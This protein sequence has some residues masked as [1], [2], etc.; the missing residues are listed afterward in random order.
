[1]ELIGTRKTLQEAFSRGWDR[2]GINMIE[3][4][5]YG[6]EIETGD[7]YSSDNSVCDGVEAGYILAAV[8]KQKP[9]IAQ[10]LEFCYGMNNSDYRQYA[11][12]SDLFA[13]LFQ[14]KRNISG[15]QIIRHQNLCF[16]AANDYRMRILN[17]KGIPL[18]VYYA[19]MNVH[20]PNWPR[21]WKI[22]H[23]YCLANLSDLDNEGVENISKMLRSLRGHSK[24][25]PSEILK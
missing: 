11:V 18:E 1:M 22:K 8:S 20:Q 15:K 21:D 5:L 23:R 3:Y 10:W 19:Y 6:E 12:A 13:D 16:L 14:G 2:H 4:M 7:F 9:R 24:K 25:R 17:G